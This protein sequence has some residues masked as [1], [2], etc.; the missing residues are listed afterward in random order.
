MQQPRL[1]TLQKLCCW[2]TWDGLE[3]ERYP[4][5]LFGTIHAVA[6]YGKGKSIQEEY[7]FIEYRLALSMEDPN[8]EIESKSSRKSGVV[9]LVALR[10]ILCRTCS[11]D[12]P[13]Q[14]RHQSI[15]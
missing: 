7:W 10:D 9:R 11:W 5:V 2:L 8:G 1:T 4:N 13:T 3:G 6:I 12:C 15:L 14:T